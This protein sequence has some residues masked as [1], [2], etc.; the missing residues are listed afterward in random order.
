MKP[1]LTFE[2][3]AS[4][5]AIIRLIAKERGK[6]AC[7]NARKGKNNV[8]S[9][10]DPFF[11]ELQSMTPP[12]SSW[13]NPGQKRRTSGEGKVARWTRPKRI[14]SARVYSSIR[15]LRARTPN[16]PWA[17]A[18]DSFISEIQ[19]M[20]AGRVPVHI[21]K[22]TIIPKYK[23]TENGTV[24]CRPICI[25]GNL[26]EKVFLALTCKYLTYVFDPFFHA[27]MLFMRG[28]RK[29][30]DGSW[31][32]P[33]C[34]DA[35]KLA[36]E[37][38]KEVGYANI[39]VGEC[40]IKKFYDIFNHED[41]LRCFDELCL[42][43]AG[44]RGVTPAFFSPVLSVLKAYLDS[45]DYWHDIMSLNDQS[46][47]VWRA[48]KNIYAT[49]AVPDP[50]CRFKWVSDADF[51]NSGCYTQEE[52]AYAKEC[53]LIGIPQGGALSGIIVNIVMQS[54][55]KNIVGSA[56]PGRLFVR[57]CDDILLMHTN[58]EKCKAYLDYYCNALRDHKLV[59][60]ERHDVAEFKAGEK[61][62]SAYWH[63]KTKNVFK[64]GS[65]GGDA[66][67]WVAFV[68]YEMRRTGEIR[69]RKDKVDREFTRIAR[70]Y[71]RVYK[72]GEPDRMA[73]F[74]GL[75]K[76]LFCDD[77]VMTN[78]RYTRAQ[79]CRLDHY[80]VRKYYQAA[81]KLKMTVATTEGLTRYVDALERKRDCFE[82]C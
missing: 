10:A 20:A 69:F 5:D 75:P 45:F 74:N 19:D 66:A 79:A 73:L 18:L 43:V 8:K 67:D 47:P 3:F 4:D 55:D 59:P 52:L 42:I 61:T 49:S 82:D 14:A 29:A 60:H 7:K 81:R 41:I 9:P 11:R 54:I 57:Y 1:L 51:V 6:C 46:N 64:W 56:D 80:M 24:I 17:V 70:T 39:Y 72:S 28:P 32:V 33:N 68:G 78:D 76:N 65:G 44:R 21:G 16:A 26:S 12:R 22:P 40:D 36:S 15:V 71:Y 50:E 77:E 37:Y 53:G 27:N 38:R 62:R 34:L 63:A 35:I 2:E 25:Y 48:V 58:R 23:E 30:G 31:H 13:I